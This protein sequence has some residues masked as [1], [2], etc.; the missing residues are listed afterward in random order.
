MKVATSAQKDIQALAWSVR[1]LACSGL[2]YRK[3]VSTQISC[4]QN[5]LLSPIIKLLANAAAVP[6]AARS[7][8]GSGVTGRSS[9]AEEGRR[10]MATFSAVESLHQRKPHFDE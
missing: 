5:G 4:T 10:I 3:N 6:K 1:R 9:N 7:R 8:Q 2:T